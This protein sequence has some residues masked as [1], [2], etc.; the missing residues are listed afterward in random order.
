MKEKH[1]LM[2]VGFFW[3]A[4]DLLETDGKMFKGWH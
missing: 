2:R 4:G 1:L 3:S